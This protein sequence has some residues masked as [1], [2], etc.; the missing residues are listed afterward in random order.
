MSQTGCCSICGERL[1]RGSEGKVCEQCLLRAA[2]RSGEQEIREEL[3]QIP[4]GAEREAYIREVSSDDPGLR[5]RLLDWLDEFPDTSPALVQTSSPITQLDPPFINGR[6]RLLQ[7]IGEGGFG[8]VYLAQQQAPV[9][10]Q[11]AVKILKLGMDTRQVVARFDLERQ[12]LAMMD[13]PGIAKVFDAGATESGRPYFVMELVRG[14]PITRYCT[15]NHLSIRQRLELF[16]D[17]CQAVQ[18]AHQKGIVHRDLK[19][20]NI[21]VAGQESTPTPKVIDFGIAKATQQELTDHTALTLEH[22]LLGTPAYLSP[23][24]AAAGNGDIDTRS[25]IYSLGVLLYELLTGSTPFDTKEL[26][27]AGLDEMRRIIREREPPRPS[28]RLTKIESAKSAAESGSKNHIR[29][30]KLDRDLDWIVLKCLQ[31]DRSRRYATANGLAMELQ[32]YLSHEPIVARPPSFSYRFSKLVRR[33]PVVISLAL[34]LGLALLL[35]SLGGTW[36]S[37]RIAAAKRETDQANRRLSRNV[38]Y[39]ESL[40]MEKLAGDG[41]RTLP[42]A[43][44]ANQVRQDPNDSVAASRALS[45]LSLH[46]FVLPTVHPLVHEDLVFTA[47]FSSDGKQILSG[48]DGG[49]ARFWDAN[50]G[51]PQGVITNGSAIV[52]GWYADNDR[53][54]VLRTRDDNVRVY[55]SLTHAL[56]LT[57]T[58]V[59]GERMGF[60]NFGGK[61]WFFAAPHGDTLTRW[62]LSSGHQV[63]PTVPFASSI[64][65][66]ECA[67]HGD[68][69]AVACADKTIHILRASSGEELW[70][71]RR[72]EGETFHPKWTP[73]GSRLFVPRDGGKRIT[74]WDFHGTNELSDLSALPGSALVSLIFAPNGRNFATWSWASPVRIWDAATLRLLAEPVSPSLQGASEYVFSPDSSLLAGISQ[75]GTARIW[76]VESGRLVFEPFEHQG[77]IRDLAFDSSGSRIVTASQDETARVWDI[78]MRLP[79]RLELPISTGGGSLCFSP[80]GSRILVSIARDTVLVCDARTGRPLSPPLQHPVGTEPAHIRDALFSHD[81][82]KI[83]TVGQEGLVRLWNARSY[84]VEHEFNLRQNGLFARFSPDDRFVVVGDHGGYT[85]VWNCTT[86]Q[87]VGIAARSSQEVTSV[88]VSPNTEAFLTASADGT[89]RCW[90][91]LTGQPV[92]PVFRH[93]GTIW[94]AVYSP[95]G[96]HLVTASADRTAQVWDVRT[97]QALL[98]PMQHAKDVFVARFS[99]DGRSILTTSE[100]ATARVW[101]AATAKPRSPLLRHSAKIW[102]GTFSPDSRWVATGSDDQTVRLWDAESG[103]PISEPLP[104]T[105]PVG[106]LCFSPDGRQLAA[107]GGQSKLWDVQVAPTPVPPFIPELIEAVAGARLASD[108]EL[109]TVPPEA[110]G[111]LRHQFSEAR[112]S[113]FYTRWAKWFLFGRR[114]QP[115][116]P[117]PVE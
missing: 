83:I 68:M 45:M 13:H 7:K 6:Y 12:A 5:K 90:A 73:D 92:G 60:M 44:L 81:G 10:R 24:Q 87:Q 34:L 114:Q 80:D 94:S 99:A 23:E 36:M 20:S 22:H 39:L 50:T 113:D 72:F 69:L 101:D 38:R 33:N 85:R 16:V 17:V 15:K 78:G 4:T 37:W 107:F 18:H 74:V 11:V 76:D 58:G 106:R 77:W 96:T 70:P 30:S 3:L 75:D 111:A 103:L 104:H 95:D 100:D 8:A 105:G 110:L 43:W 112:E 35:A 47:R 109:Q 2:L 53:R 27:Q 62:D 9:Q 32:R 88:D 82:S 57:L 46:N 108:G 66:L 86:G 115:A 89:A 117:C 59:D 54:V 67:V 84:Q 28:T 29:K 41:R 31:K 40:E 56:V 116:P 52:A 25:D 26:G 42:L 48:G 93:R 102:A 63:G 49:K 21:L 64:R 97:G 19:P 91:L 14:V 79:R 71:A 55:D 98:K 61:P 1:G 51:E 65:M